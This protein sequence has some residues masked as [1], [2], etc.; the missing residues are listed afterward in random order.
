MFYN[1]DY[2]KPESVRER[3][4]VFNNMQLQSYIDSSLKSLSIIGECSTRKRVRIKS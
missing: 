1:V 4:F 2:L 3:C